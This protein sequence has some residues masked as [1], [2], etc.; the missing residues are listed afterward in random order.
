MST[1]QTTDVKLEIANITAILK[2]RNNL[3]DQEATEMIKLEVEIERL[4]PP[5]KKVMKI[6]TI[7]R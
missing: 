4:M 3:N 5:K 1:Q 6:H 2:T 7:Y